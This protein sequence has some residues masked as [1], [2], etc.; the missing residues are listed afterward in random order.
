MNL[1]TKIA[2]FGAITFWSSAFVCIRIGLQAY[3]PEGMALLRFL[4]ASVIMGIIYA[5][6][7]TPSQSTWRD[8]VCLLFTGMLGIGIYNI[9]LNH[10]EM[11]VSSGVAS[12][13]TSQS[14]VVTT[15]F[16]ILFLGESLTL[17]RLLGFLISLVGVCII[18][19]GEIGSMQLSASMLYMFAALISGSLFT[20]MQK[21]LLKRCHPIEATCYV[22]WGGTLLLMLYVSHLTREIVAA[23]LSITLTIVYMGIFPAVLSYI[24]W[25]YVLQKMPVSRLVSYLYSLPFVTSLMG[26]LFL[27]EVPAMLSFVG[28]V[29]SIAGVW[30]VNQSYNKTSAKLTPVRHTE[31]VVSPSS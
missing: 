20:I 30:L 18:A 15:L 21:P 29:I 3:S 7:P 1:K 27:G 19:F 31:R 28:A 2:I 17:H 4:V 23:P 5:L 13:I 12:F 16:A 26:W 11:A 8:K 25:S 6:V 14:P 24:A 22:I 10:G 9:T